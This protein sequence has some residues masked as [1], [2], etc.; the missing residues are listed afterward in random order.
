[1][2][3]FFESFD[4][5]MSEPAVRRPGAI[6]SIELACATFLVVYTAGALLAAPAM[7]SDSAWGFAVWQSMEQGAAFNFGVEPDPQNI[8]TDIGR[9]QTWWTPGQYLIPGLLT[10]L[11]ISLGHAI[12][13]TTALFTALGLI[14][15][16]LVYRALE[17]SELVNVLSVAIIAGERFCTLPFG[18]YNGGEV[19]LFGASPYLILISLWAMRDAAW[20][21]ALLA[22]A[23]LL[24]FF[25]KSSALVLCLAMAAASVLASWRPP[26]KPSRRLAWLRWPASCLITGLLAYA[27]F[28]SR[29]RSPMQPTFR[30]A[31]HAVGNTLFATVSPM[32]GALSLDDALSWILAKPPQPAWPQWQVSLPVIGPL[33][34]LALAIY[35][36]V[37]RSAGSSVYRRVL[38]SMI[39]VYVALFV[40]A[41]F[42]GASISCEARH[43]RPAS[44][45][46]LPGLVAMVANTKSSTL[47][48][49]GV[50]L[51]VVVVGYGLASYVN[52]W[53]YL[54]RH[55]LVG[56]RGVTQLLLDRP[57]LDWLHET[58]QRYPS[59]A[60]LF[61]LPAP[62]FALEVERG[63]AIVTLADF[64][65][66]ETLAGREYHGRVEHLFVLLPE[67][68]DS[69]GKSAAIL[70]SFIDY[71]DWTATQVG[72]FQV[73]QPAAETRRDESR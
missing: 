56:K 49:L 51:A 58:D 60:V 50:A 41:L 25:L 16:R 59:R 17:F 55:D 13:V 26:A 62:G 68:F 3:L 29:G 33:A 4:L 32:L 20:R 40:V 28:L 42:V 66:R 31:D 46:L 54:R 30:I 65:S 21:A 63:R 38:L 15:W 14:G 36:S 71:R 34:L 39:V 67:H 6:R 12:V 18:M 70:K 2:R 5:Q 11:G 69:N 52:R 8:A 47:R 23:F 27:L 61:Y 73:Y 45:V 24:G 57:A 64:D 7:Y 19:L 44:L 72:A 10:H 48:W 1:M 9:F 53:Q 22:P 43:V 37:Y 35:V